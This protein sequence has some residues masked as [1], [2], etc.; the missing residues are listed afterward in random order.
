MEVGEWSISSPASKFLL[1]APWSEK[2]AQ[3]W[4]HP[5]RISPNQ[6]RV[7]GS[8]SSW[9]PG[10]FKQM[11][12]CTSDIL[13]SFTT[14]SSEVALD[15]K[16]DELPKGASSVL[17]LLKATYL[18][19]LSFVFVTVDGK[20]HKSFLLD[21]AGEHTLSIHLETETSEDNL[22]RLPGFNDTHHVSVYLPCLQSAFV[23]N[24]RG[25]GTFFSPD[26][27]KK[28]LAVFG[29]SIAQGFVV[30]RPDKTWPRSLA[31]R[32]K[33]DVVNQGIGGQVYQPG[34]YTFIEDA[35]LVIVAL[36]A[37]YR[38]EKCSK[39]Q[40][41]YDIQNS[42]WQI[43]QMYADTR[44]VVLTPTPYFEDTYPTHPY[45]CF[46]EIPQIIEEVAGKFG[47][48]CISGEKLLPQEKKYFA[49]D[50]HPNSKGAALLAKNLFEALKQPAQDSL[51]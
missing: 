3:G 42:L 12:A 45:S 21:D 2:L 18:K 35:S 23:K 15:L 5:L 51:F 7:I 50:V 37:N 20:P 46:A 34:S 29:D 30:E 4:V 6:L 38:Y 25:N 43:S 39:S 32:M 9:H 28:K 26:E 17:Q 44:V 27:P 36:G 8:C 48:Q 31:K 10:L 1:G 24:L 47:L 33:L 16:I 19:K 14:D 13:V 49:D 22:A 40:V 11:A 41:T